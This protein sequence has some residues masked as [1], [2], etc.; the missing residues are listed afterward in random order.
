MIERER[1]ITGVALSTQEIRVSLLSLPDQPGIV[2][3]LFQSLA[4][5]HINV[6]MIIQS[7]ERDTGQNP[8]MSDLAFTVHDNQLS[9]VRSCLSDLKEVIQADHV[10][11]DEVAKLS[12]VGSG[13]RDAPGVA[14]TL[15]DAL[16]HVG[17]NIKSISTS[18][19][20]ISVLLDRQ[21][22]QKGLVAVHQA[23]GLDK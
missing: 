6:D 5:A 15:F 1:L 20:K 17:I 22:G 3:Q 9:L 4:K 7:V 23:F 14:A 19:I 13:M 2:S 11:E 12:I 8:L 16:S 18:D 21:H 10:L